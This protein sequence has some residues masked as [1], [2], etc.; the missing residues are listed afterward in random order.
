M[1]FSELAVTHMLFSKVGLYFTS[2]QLGL[3]CYFV[4]LVSVHPF[5]FI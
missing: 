4:S 2:E 1:F 5:I 3:S